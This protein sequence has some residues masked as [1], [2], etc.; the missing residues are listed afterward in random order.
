MAVA[1][2]PA[3]ESTP[4]PKSGSDGIKRS[5]TRKKF[6]I[7]RGSR[8]IK[9]KENTDSR[10]KVFPSPMKIKF[11]MLVSSAAASTA[12]LSTG[13][14]FTHDVL[15]VAVHDDRALTIPPRSLPGQDGT[16]NSY[17]VLLSWIK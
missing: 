14:S 15:I 17:L 1:F 5:C 11:K 12:G 16:S 7:K 4:L 6:V 3:A 9:K 2:T 8:A 10:R 13:A